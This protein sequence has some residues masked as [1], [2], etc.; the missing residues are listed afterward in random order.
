MDLMQRHLVSDVELRGVT[1]KTTCSFSNRFF[2]LLFT[3]RSMGMLLS[4]ALYGPPMPETSNPSNNFRG[5]ARETM[6]QGR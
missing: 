4:S 1:L 6:P 5:F 2:S 3:P